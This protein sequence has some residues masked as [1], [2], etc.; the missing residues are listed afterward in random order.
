MLDE[1]RGKEPYL[2]RQI[3]AA[4]LHDQKVIDGHYSDTHHV[5]SFVCWAPAQ[6]GAPIADKL[7]CLIAVDEPSANGHYGA[8][9]A[10][11]FVQKVLQFALEH[12]RVPKVD[13]PDPPKAERRRQ[14]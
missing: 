6:P 5:G 13:K 4:Q 3:V 14:R 7:V 11:P 9:V 12:A 2:I 1:A 8:E 10:A